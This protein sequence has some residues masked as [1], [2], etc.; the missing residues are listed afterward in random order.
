MAMA[1]T[2]PAIELLTEPVAYLEPPSA[3]N[4]SQN[5]A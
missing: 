2:W 1:G 3:F 4:F 5:W